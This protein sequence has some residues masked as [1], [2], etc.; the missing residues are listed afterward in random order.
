[1]SA[2]AVKIMRSYKPFEGRNPPRRVT[3]APAGRPTL[4]SLSG[5]PRSLAFGPGERRRAA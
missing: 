3:R 5:S 2:H 4:P 1:V